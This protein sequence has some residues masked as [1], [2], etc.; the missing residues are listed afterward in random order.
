MCDF[1]LLLIIAIVSLAF[2]PYA[3]AVVVCIFPALLIVA[4][5][6]AVYWISHEVKRD[7]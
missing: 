7:E 1:I 2:L 3:I 5:V 4:T 6:Y